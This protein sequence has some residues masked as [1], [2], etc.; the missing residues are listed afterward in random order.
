MSV[1]VVFVVAFF[2]LGGGGGGAS[3]KSISLMVYFGFMLL[4]THNYYHFLL[5]LSFKFIS[6]NLLAS[7]RL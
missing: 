1:F 2:F 4:C 6:N 3:V 5:F 7:G